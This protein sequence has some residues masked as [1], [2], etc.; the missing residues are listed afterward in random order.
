PVMFYLT[1]LRTPKPEEPFKPS[2]YFG[3]S[4]QT[5]YCSG[6]LFFLL[7]ND[8]TYEEIFK[9]RNLEDFVWA[10]RNLKNIE[11]FLSQHFTGD[12]GL[13]NNLKFYALMRL[14]SLRALRRNTNPNLEIRP[15]PLRFYPFG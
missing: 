12:Q 8:S 10:A 1:P 4:R 15:L 9:D 6:T 3:F 2:S 14:P 5:G 11:L 7:K 13:R